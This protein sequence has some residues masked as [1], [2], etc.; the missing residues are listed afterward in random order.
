VSDD[1]DDPGVG[2][3]ASGQHRRRFLR[4]TGLTALSTAFAGCEHDDD[5]GSSGTG[6]TTKKPLKNR[7]ETAGQVGLTSQGIQDLGYP[8]NGPSAVSFRDQDSLTYEGSNADYS[9]ILEEWKLDLDG[10]DIPTKVVASPSVVLEG[11][12]RNPV[13]NISLRDHVAAPEGRFGMNWLEANGVVSG[14][15]NEFKSGPTQVRS[16]TVNLL[17]D[18]GLLN[19]KTGYEVYEGEVGPTSSSSRSDF[20][21]VQIALVRVDDAGDAVILGCAAGAPATGGTVPDS[22]LRYVI[23]T[24]MPEVTR[25]PPSSYPT[26]GTTIADARLVQTVADTRVDGRNPPFVVDDPDLGIDEYVAPLVEMGGG[27]HPS[28]LYFE[29]SGGQGGD[30]FQLDRSDLGNGLDGVASAFDSNVRS[31]ALEAPTPFTLT[32]STGSVTID[33]E[34]PCGHVLNSATISKGSNGYTTHDVGDMR[35]GFITCQGPTSIGSSY[36]TT[37]TYERTV[38]MA[39]QYL[40][41]VFPGNLVAYRYDNTFTGRLA[42][43]PANVRANYLPFLGDVGE[44][45]KGLEQQSSF[46][47]ASTPDGELFAQNRS[48]SSAA[49]LLK[50]KGFNAW[51]LIVPAGYYS[52]HRLDASGMT[53]PAAPNANTNVGYNFYAASAVEQANPNA[54]DREATQTVA[55]ELGHFYDDSFGRLYAGGAADDPMAQRDD[56]NSDA[57]INNRPVDYAHARYVGSDENTNTTTD[58]PGLASL[59]FDFTGG[60]FRHVTRFTINPTTASTDPGMYI[61]DPSAST[62]NP[63]ER[64]E[65]YMSYADF[66]SLWS[67]AHV[68]QQLIDA[69]WT[70][71]TAQE[72]TFVARGIPESVADGGETEDGDTADDTEDEE[73]T[74]PD[75]EPTDDTSEEWRL[76]F[77]E[78][79]VYPDHPMPEGL[80]GSVPVS[81]HGPEGERLIGRQAP[82]GLSLLHAEGEAPV[83][84]VRLP[85]PERAVEF[86]AERNGR[87]VRL[88]AVVRPVRD[89]IGRLSDDDFRDDVE[90]PRSRLSEQLTGVER[91]MSDRQYGEA[92]EEMAIVGERLAEFLREDVDEVRMEQILTLVERMTGRLDRLGG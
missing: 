52:Y 48:N 9:V 14:N 55:H 2:G 27:T 67:D 79:S 78:T 20:T 8:T 19:Q 75:E 25:N 54:S 90:A 36:G 17:I 80:E 62:A 10:G 85:F 76:A 86:R 71:T 82:E 32:R 81:L 92:A 39:V 3:D 91:L 70:E 41:R 74:D 59:A 37:S 40:R 31:A 7:T 84:P 16:S 33:V 46:V 35:V 18:H 83:V 13:V 77:E 22:R 23:Q 49:S 38:D 60:T 24:A 44:A 53:V 4:A 42:V 6:S 63:P 5:D 26:S 73:P 68:H 88:N 1:T 61:N 34:A 50:T 65:S 15:F 11:Q 51:V 28:R 56:R 66:T 43:G 57:T 30:T 45:R 64:L 87:T 21:T 58:N 89:A 69:D 47:T 29:S 72:L 12:E